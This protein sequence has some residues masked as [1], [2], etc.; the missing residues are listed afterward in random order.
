MARG[1]NF[2]YQS[3]PAEAIGAS[4]GKALFGD[5]EMAAAQ[6]RARTEAA[7]REAQTAEATAHGGLYTSQTTGQDY[8]NTSAQGQ[9]GAIADF[10]S[11]S[12]LASHPGSSAAPVA[13]PAGGAPASYAPAPAEDPQLTRALSLGNVLAT[14]A[15]SQ[16]DKVSTTDTMGTLSA[17]MGGPDADQ[18]GRA[19]NIILHGSPTKDFAVTSGRADQI[20][21]TDNAANLA[22]AIATAST[23]HAS[24][25]PVAN[26]SAGARRDAATINH[27]DDIAS[28]NIRADAKRDVATIK[29][30]GGRDAG[31][32]LVSDVLPG[33]VMTG[34]ERT[35]ARNA[36]VGGVANSRHLAGDG[37]EA[38]DIKPFYG[39]RTFADAKAAMQARYGARL[40]EAKDET[41]RPGHG[42]HWHFAVRSE[43][44]PTRAAS[45]K[46]PKGVSPASSKMLTDELVTQI[47]AEGST[48]PP[49]IQT[50][51]R[52]RA[53]TLFR[54]T[55]DPVASVRRAMQDAQ[56][57]GAR[58]KPAVGGGGLTVGRIRSDAMAAIAQGA[59]RSAVAAGFKQK[60]GQ[61]L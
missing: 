44:G 39:A 20:A 23:N 28:E 30:G 45:A 58:E 3:S 56:A 6:A 25:I 46:P 26:I 2:F 47:A 12:Y 9:P 33:A 55:G 59:S 53:I 17:L 22:Q 5:P 40:V 31:F 48:I 41:H 29:G 18:Q 27:R 7:L 37:I 54:Q 21:A 50:A 14:L 38:Y 36:E 32:S 4:L 19:A 15:G 1:Q 11:K 13:L 57:S 51:I 24:D 49:R 52:S 43:G 34:G 60:T 42:P 8:Q 35:A 16:G 10:I 61:A